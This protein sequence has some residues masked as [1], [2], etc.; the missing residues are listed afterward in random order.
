MEVICVSFRGE[1]LVRVWIGDEGACPALTLEGPPLLR[2]PILPR[3][4]TRL[5]TLLFFRYALLA[6]TQAPTALLLHLPFC[7]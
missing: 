1:S 4:A 3:P 7:Q 5:T 6:S 2:L